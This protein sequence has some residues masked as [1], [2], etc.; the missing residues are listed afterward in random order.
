MT[1]TDYNTDAILNEMVEVE[2]SDPQKFN[3]V[4]ET[5]TR[6]GIQNAKKRNL[7]QSCHI[8]HKQGRY[9]LAHF[10]QMIAM[11]GYRADMTDE[12]HNRLLDITNLL[13]DW[14]LVNVLDPDFDPPKMNQFRV[15]KV[16][17]AEEWN[18]VPKF[19]IGKYKRQ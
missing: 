19:T 16:S 4:R 11:D 10:K 6:I 13:S 7:Y 15:L 9:Y 1:H 18:L 5:L 3:I 14:N 12:D 2:L 17:D 8:L